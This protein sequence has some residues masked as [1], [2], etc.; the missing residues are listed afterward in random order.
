[1]AIK[2][3]S[4]PRFWALSFSCPDSCLERVRRQSPDEPV[5]GAREAAVEIVSP[6]DSANDR[7]EAPELSP[8]GWVP[9]SE[10]IVL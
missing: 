9:V 8:G 6:P 2:T 1:M 4:T 7:L 5:R 3:P 10:L